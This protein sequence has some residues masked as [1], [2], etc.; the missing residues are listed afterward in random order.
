M[1]DRLETT[2]LFDVAMD[3]LAGALALIAAHWLGRLQAGEA[4]AL[5]DP[6]DG[7]LRN[8]DFQ[9]NLLA[10]FSRAK[11][12]LDAAAKLSTP[13]WLHDL[14]MAAEEIAGNKAKEDTNDARRAPRAGPPSFGNSQFF[15]AV[16][17][18]FARPSEPAARAP[19]LVT[20]NTGVKM[21][22]STIEPRQT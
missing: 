8:S 3:E 14:R 4:E 21:D 7:G 1:A 17:F 19:L 6:A 11:K 15:V 9:S 10:G 12:A 5:Q 13:W 2:E 20:Q 16:A 18:T 22:E